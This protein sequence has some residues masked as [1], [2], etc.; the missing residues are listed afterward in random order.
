MNYKEEIAK[1]TE[2]ELAKWAKCHRLLD[3]HELWALCD[4]L[5]RREYKLEYLEDIQKEKNLRILIWKKTKEKNPANKTSF[6]SV[7]R[8]TIKTSLPRDI[9]MSSAERAVKILYWEIIISE[10][11]CLRAIR[12]NDYKGTEEVTIIYCDGEL[13]IECRLLESSLEFQ[14]KSKRINEFKLAFNE[15]TQELVSSEK[16]EEEL[17]YTKELERQTEYVVPESLSKPP[18]I[19]EQKWFYFIQ[20]TLL[21]TSILGCLLAMFSSFIYYIFLFDSAI[22]VAVAFVYAFLVKKSNVSNFKKIIISGF[23]SILTIYFLSQLIRFLFIVN[24]HNIIDASIFDYFQEKF[25][26]GIQIEDFDLGSIGLVVA[27]LVELATSLGSFYL[28]FSM[29]FTKIELEKIPSDVLDFVAY[30][31][32]EGKNDSEIRNEL[33]RMG[34]TDIENQNSVLAFF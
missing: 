15:I 6:K 7:L 9:V 14:R 22:G 31:I 10:K 34:W 25:N 26:A 3:N 16:I 17:Q 13:T 21:L 19:K 33:S 20:G 23:I 18:V 29:K 32:D 30:L 2:V 12:S 1:K 5:K 4:E 28:Y 8:S 11:D 24:K 27:W